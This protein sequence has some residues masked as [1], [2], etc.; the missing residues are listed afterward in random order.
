MF[1]K[2]A[3]W[4][5]CLLS[6]ARLHHISSL[7]KCLVIIY[8]LVDLKPKTIIFLM[9]FCYGDY[10]RCFPFDDNIKINRDIKYPEEWDLVQSDISSVEGWCTASYGKFIISRTKCIYFSRRRNIL[11]YTCNYKLC[12]SSITRIDSIKDLRLFLHSKLHFHNHVNYKFFKLI[13][14]LGLLLSATFSLPS[15]DYIYLLYFTLVKSKLSNASS[16]WNSITS[17]D[18]NNQER[19]QLKSAVLYFNRFFDHVY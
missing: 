8:A 17:A 4:P 18:N 14:L 6:F 15:L 3:V 10:S 16:I 9:D 19:V 12:Q 7:M 13:M 11:I 5:N 1:V 2:R